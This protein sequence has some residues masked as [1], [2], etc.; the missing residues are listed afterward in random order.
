MTFSQRKKYILAHLMP[1][2]EKTF[3]N[4]DFLTF[5]CICRKLKL[6]QIHKTELNEVAF[7]IQGCAA[8]FLYYLSLASYSLIFL[9][10][11]LK[12]A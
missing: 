11:Y 9:N 10:M 4:T 5:F 1:V 6:F 7:D 2:E 12:S 3:F 8:D